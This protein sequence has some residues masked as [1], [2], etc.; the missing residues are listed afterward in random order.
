M[1]DWLVQDYGLSPREAYMHMDVNP[2]VR[3][4]VYQMIMLRRINYTVGV[5][6]PKKFL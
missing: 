6:F 1:I 2:E 3:I 5:S 4:N